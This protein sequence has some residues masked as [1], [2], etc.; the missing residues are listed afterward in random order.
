VPG[1]AVPAFTVRVALPPAVTDEGFKLAE[2][3]AGAPLTDRLT[4]SAVPETIAVEMVLLPVPFWFMVSV[5][6]LAAM[7]KSLEAVAPQEG[8]RNDATRV[9]QLK[10]PFAGMY[11][12]VYQNVQSSVG[13]TAIIE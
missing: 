11:S 6:G 2:A 13:S 5:L 9:R 4:V 10:V 7:L 8:K 12:V 1:A 3:P